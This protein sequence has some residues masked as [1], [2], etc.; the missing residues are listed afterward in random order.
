VPEA[1]RLPFPALALL[2]RREPVQLAFAFEFATRSSEDMEDQQTTR[3]P[4]PA[5]EYKKKASKRPAK[6]RSLF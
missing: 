6:Q 3:A 4:S 1:I 5:K 2:R